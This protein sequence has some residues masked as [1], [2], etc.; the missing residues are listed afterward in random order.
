MKKKVLLIVGSGLFILFVLISSLYVFSFR[1]NGKRTIEVE[2]LDTYKDLGY[3]ANIFGLS[4]KGFVKTENNVNTSKIGTY[5]V[6]YKLP[7]KILTRE[8]HVVDKEVPNLTLNGESEIELNIG[9]EYEELGAVAIDN[10]DNDITDK[11]SIENLIDINKLGEYQ[12]I[13]KVEDSSGNKVEKIRTVKVL[14]KEVPVITL[15]GNKKNTV[16][17][18][19]EYTE[20]GYTAIDNVDSDITKNVKIERNIDFSKSGTYTIKYSV[21]DSSSNCTEITRT[22]EVIEQIDITYIKGIL[23]VNKKYHLPANYNPGVNSE[24]YQALTKL[25]NDASSNGYSLPL[26]SGFRSYETQKNLFN[27]YV[28]RNGYEKANTFSARP[29]ESEHQTGLAFDIGEISDSF[30]NTKAGI[31]LSENAHRYGFIIR[32]LKGKESIT[33]YKYEPWHIRYVGVSAATEIKTQGITLEEYLGV[34]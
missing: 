4:L 31:W 13:Y 33:G 6:T 34:A 21:C 10:V 29:G 22:I 24:A 8:V 20:E 5:K 18:N 11:I 28:A 9:S 15:K 14:D 23:L 2:Y 3:T 12:V 7:F 19:G 32:Y 30:G 27:S 17:L 16:K 1:L 25:Q 26:L